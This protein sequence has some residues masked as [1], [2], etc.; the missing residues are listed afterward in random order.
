M[1]NPNTSTRP[2]STRAETLNKT[3]LCRK[4]NR[5]YRKLLRK[6]CGNNRKKGQIDENRTRFQKIKQNYC[7]A[8]KSTNA[9][10]GRID[11]TDFKKDI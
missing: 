2:S 8:K 7:E 4:G 9:E 10:Y 1:T 5:N 11:I 6:S 3:R